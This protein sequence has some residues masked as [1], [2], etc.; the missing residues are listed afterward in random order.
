MI[1]ARTAGTPDAPP[2]EQSARRVMACRLALVDRSLATIASG[3]ATAEAVHRLRVATR[4]AGAC[5]TAF[6]PF[7]PHRQRRWFRTSLGRIRRA[8]GETRDIDVLLARCL[9]E[10]SAARRAARRRLADLLRGWRP[11]ARRPLE[12]VA[13]SGNR[14]EWRDRS[15][16]LLEVIDAS[17]HAGSAAD[18]AH[19]RA[20]RLTTKFLDRFD[21]GIRG[22]DDAHR[23]RIECKKLRYVLEALSDVASVDATSAG[24][25]VLQGLQGRFGEFTDHAA[26][27]DR[28]ARWLRRECDRSIRRVLRARRRKESRLASAGLHRCDAWWTA[29]RRRTVRRKLERMLRRMARPA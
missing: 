14:R 13:R 24:E 11:A 21:H 20:V 23:F 10:R 22:G 25:R 16:S 9:V 3:D 29:A 12:A 17:G 4:R 19:C 5:I 6:K 18:F 26:A 8:A 15:A 28:L 27:A 2:L 1:V 7:L